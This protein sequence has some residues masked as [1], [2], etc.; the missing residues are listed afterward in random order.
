[1]NWNM[2]HYGFDEKLKSDYELLAYPDFFLIDP[3][4]RFWASPAD[5]P[6]G[7]LEYDLYKIMNP[8][9]KFP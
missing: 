1:M 6:S 3:Q 4:G 5:M 9:K 8:G 7:R 2:L